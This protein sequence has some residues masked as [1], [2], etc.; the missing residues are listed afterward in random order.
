MFE[1]DKVRMLVRVAR[2]LMRD[3]VQVGWMISIQGIRAAYD[4]RIA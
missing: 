4:R 2:A 1:S 3:P